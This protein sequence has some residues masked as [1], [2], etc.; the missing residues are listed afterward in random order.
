MV[1][2]GTLVSN[3]LLMV[4]GQGFHGPISLI[5]AATLK[6]DRVDGILAVSRALGD[7]DYKRGTGGP[8]NQ[9]VIAKPDITRITCT[10]HPLPFG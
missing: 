8:L 3:D 1:G 5:W 9:K 10:T 2:R 7:A 6:M 4:G